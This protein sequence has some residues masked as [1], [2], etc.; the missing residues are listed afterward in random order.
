M[1]HTENLV[2]GTH[3]PDHIRVLLVDDESIN[4]QVT[5][6]MLKHLG[7]TVE[8]AENGK[9]A[10]DLLQQRHYNLVLMDCQMPCMD[11]YEATREFRRLES[12]RA[13]APSLPI[14][15]L[16]SFSVAKE[17]QLCLAA[18]MD[19]CL[20]KPVTLR[21]LQEKLM[22]WL[23]LGA[24]APAQGGRVDQHQD[25]VKI[26]DAKK[27]ADLKQALAGVPGA[28]A[29]LVG[30]FLD[31][32]ESQI[33]EINQALIVGEFAL[34][35]RRAHSLKSQSATFGAMTLSDLLKQLELHARSGDL[36]AATNALKRVQTEFSHVKTA[37]ENERLPQ[38]QPLA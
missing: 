4:R 31:K 24:A 3:F 32:S 1:T 18:G 20:T 2:G 11:G 29:D 21:I 22:F 9:E 23:G 10:L 15:A 12:R 33:V 5:T 38:P 35:Q 8:V 27:L 19:D 25:P 17:R 37:L 26:L 6:T 7:I 30:Q 34:V 13:T 28:F 36:S 14:L 16:S